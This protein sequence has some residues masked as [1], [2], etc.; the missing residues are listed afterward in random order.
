MIMADHTAAATAAGEARASAKALVLRGQQSWNKI[1]MALGI[2]LAIELPFVFI[3]PPPWNVII[4]AG[5]VA[6]TVRL[7]VFDGLFQDRLLGL[8]GTIE[9]KPR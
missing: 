9:G 1:W 7:F 6:L 8:I 2:A 5:L 3:L 4:A